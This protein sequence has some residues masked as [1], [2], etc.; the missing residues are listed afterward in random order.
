MASDY[1]DDSGEKMLDGFTRFGERMGMRV[2]Y[3]RSDRLQDACD[4]VR[5]QTSA[6]EAVETD[7][8]TRVEWA[9]LDMQEFRAVEGYDELKQDIEERLDARDI[10]TAWFEDAES[11]REYLLFRVSDAQGVWDCFGEISRE[12]GHEAGGPDGRRRDGRTLE[13]RAE[14]AREAA[15]ALEAERAGD[16]ALSRGPRFQETRAR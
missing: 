2:V 14:Q 10:E 8:E 15:A 9:R 11:G 4:N 5:S 13:E 16:A 7:G 3:R 6:H 12:A 1:G